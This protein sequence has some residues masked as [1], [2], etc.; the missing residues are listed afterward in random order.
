MILDNELKQN[1]VSKN[2]HHTD[3]DIWRDRT[4]IMYVYII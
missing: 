3:V 2:F 1:S 4:R